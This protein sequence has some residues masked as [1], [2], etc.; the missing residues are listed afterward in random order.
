MFSRCALSLTLTVVLA[1]LASRAQTSPPPDP[2]KDDYSH[3]AAVAEEMSTKLA[4][5]ND[6]NFTQEQSVRIRVQ[7]DTGVKQFGL[8]TFPF[9]SATQTMEI[10][11]VR[12]RKPDGSTVTTP[13]DNVQ[14]LDSEITRSAPFY[15]DQREK[16]VAVKGLG[17]GDVLEYAVHLRTTK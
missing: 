5:D 6:G 2:A 15:S 17:K 14:E 12:V 11:Y 3:E 4:F 10:D 7:T 1:S 8:L 16:H 13:P 9:Q